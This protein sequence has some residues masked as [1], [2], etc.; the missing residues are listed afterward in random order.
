[1]GRGANGR[2][3]A[4]FAPRGVAGAVVEHVA[5]R[6]QSSHCVWCHG[7]GRRAACGVPG[8]VV[9]PRVVLR[10]PSLRRMGVA[11][12]VVAP[13]GCRGRRRCAACGVAV[14]VAVFAPRGCWSSRRV[15]VA[16]AVVAPHGCRGHGRCAAWVSRS[17]A[18]CRVWR[19]GRGR[20]AARGVPGAV[21]A[22]RVVSR[23]RS[24]CRVVLRLG[25]LSL[26]RVVPQ[27]QSPTRRVR[28]Q[29]NG[30]VGICRRRRGR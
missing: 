8:A 16:G 29:G 1:V 25:W 26:C 9:A 15:G 2:A 19:R 23:S 27:L 20:R 14:A 21:I 4:V 6:S 7:R 24:S 28:V 12:A 11:V 10:V 13:R 3:V 18:L 5:S 30:E 22:P 17:P